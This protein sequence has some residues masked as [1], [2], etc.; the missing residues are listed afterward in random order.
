MKKTNK[1]TTKLKEITKIIKKQS[2]KTI[3]TQLRTIIKKQTSKTINNSI[4]NNHQKLK[5]KTSIKS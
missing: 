4:K 1:N 2:L 5:Q 3:K